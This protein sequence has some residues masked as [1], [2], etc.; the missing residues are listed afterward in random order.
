MI[1]LSVRLTASSGKQALIR[2]AITTAAVALGV[3]MLLVTLAEINA[4]NAQDARTAWLSTGMPG[5]VASSQSPVGSKSPAARPAWWLFS[6]DYFGHL[7]IDRVDVAATGPGAPVPRGLPH[8]PGPGQFYVSPALARLLRSSPPAELGHRFPGHLAGTIGSSALPAPDSLIIVVGYRPGQ[9][10]RAPG[11]VE[12]TSIATTPRG[13][14]L[15]GYD[16]TTLLSILAVAALALLFPVLIFIGTATRLGA[17][18]QEQRLA[19]MRLVGATAR[20][21]SVVAAIESCITAVGGVVIGFGLFIVLHPVLQDASFTGVRLARG[22]FSLD[23]AD[24][25]LIVAGIPAAA[26]AAAHLGMRRVRIS[27]LGVAR[28]TMPSAPRAYRMFPLLAGIGELGYFAIAGHPRSSSGQIEAYFLGFFLVM[29]GLV[30]AGPWLT[31][32]GSRIMAGR[33]SRPAAL[34][35]GRRLADNPWAAF[36]AIGG[37]IV[38]LFVTSVSAGITTTIIADRGSS[39]NGVA[40]SGTLADQFITGESVSGK[41]LTA[42]AAVP[43]AVLT[44]LT[45]I[46]GIRGVTVIHT[47]P[48]AVTSPGQNENDMPGLV[49]CAQLALTPAAGRCARGAAVA[50]ITLDLSG[51]ATS[52]SQSTTE[53]HGAAMSLQRLQRLPVLMVIVGTDGASAVIERARTALEA[54]FPYLGPPAVLTTSY[55]LSAY[56]ALQRMTDVVIVASLVIAGCSLA[57]SVAAGLADRQRPFSLLRL[58]GA[59]LGLLRRVVALES[60]VPLVVVAAISAGTGFL[61]SALFLRSEL[62][63]SLRPPGGAYYII[64]LAGLLGSFAVIGCTFP[65]LKWI[66]GPE[67]ARNG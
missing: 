42:V 30:I 47:N 26:A 35:A 23:L 34:I 15:P 36:R 13:N 48:N 45:S 11:A 24:I 8:L 60:A 29:A 28:R 33:T 1:R 56:A 20:Q 31:V 6:T 49:S 51:A 27:P 17:A 40:G 39:A 5:D 14:G 10:S 3:G 53:W 57:V 66:T 18:R 50:S 2:L 55:S 59:P 64:V 43:A 9:L 44:G 54:D 25:L 7:I 21:T 19:A 12:V 58:A 67:I 65:L 46:P 22:D 61:A 32:T 62:G 41:A 37:L 38:A 63:E 16:P 4:I 52:G